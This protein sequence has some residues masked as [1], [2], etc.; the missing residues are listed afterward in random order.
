MDQLAV[1]SD[2]GLV[3]AVAHVVF[4]VY[5]LTVGRIFVSR[6]VKLRH[7]LYVLGEHRRKSNLDGLFLHGRQGIVTDVEVPKCG[8]NGFATLWACLFK[9]SGHCLGLVT[10]HRLQAILDAFFVSLTWDCSYPCRKVAGIFIQDIVQALLQ[11]A[12]HHRVRLV[13]EPGG[14]RFHD[15]RAHFLIVHLPVVPAPQPR[16]GLEANRRYRIIESSGK[17]G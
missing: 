17:G 16:G 4:K 8:Q 14:E 13:T 10:R 7:S 15:A 12:T 3:K 11:T 9:N 5:G 6:L 2:P 1:I